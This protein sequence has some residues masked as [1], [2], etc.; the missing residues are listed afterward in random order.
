MA[1]RG[2]V[3]QEDDVALPDFFLEMFAVVGEGGGID[4]GC[5]YAVRRAESG[6]ESY[7]WEDLLDGLGDEGVFDEGGY[8]RGF[9]YAFVAADGYADCATSS[10][11][12]LRSRDEYGRT[13]G[14]QE[15]AR[16]WMREN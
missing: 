12:I 9:A 14:H 16:C 1:V 7:G 5:C 10:V 3:D 6:W 15:D 13:G 4:Y 8:E 2:A 11:E